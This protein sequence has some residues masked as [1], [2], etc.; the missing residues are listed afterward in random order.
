M[1]QIS[2]H[3]VKMLV[4]EFLGKILPIIWENK[5]TGHVTRIIYLYICKYKVSQ[6]DNQ[7]LLS[8]SHIS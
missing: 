2:V 6:I 1:S 3:H 4:N 7:F 8:S 5:L